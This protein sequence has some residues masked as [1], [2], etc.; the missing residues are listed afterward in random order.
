M[1]DDWKQQ[2]KTAKKTF[3]DATNRNKPSQP[4]MLFFA[5]STGIEQGLSDCEKAHENLHAMKLIV[6]SNPKTPVTGIEKEALAKFSKAV[7]AYKPKADAYLIGV[8]KSLDGDKLKDKIKEPTKK[9]L[10]ALKAISTALEDEI[11]FWT[12]RHSGS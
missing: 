1:P 12:A 5:K 9:L 4:F 10:E 3:E 11:K 8:Q 7:T 2:W 6:K